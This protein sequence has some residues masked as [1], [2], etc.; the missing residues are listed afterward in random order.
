[1]VTNLNVLRVYYLTSVT[2]VFKPLFLFYGL[3]RCCFGFI[4]ELSASLF[5]A[6][7]PLLAEKVLIISI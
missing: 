3:S 5:S 1:M 4:L 6:G 7:E 2:S